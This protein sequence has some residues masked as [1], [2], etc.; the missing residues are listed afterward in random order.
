LI[1]IVIHEIVLF[2][3]EAF[4]H[5]SHQYEH[6][7]STRNDSRNS[8]HLAAQVQNVPSKLVVK[9]LYCLFL[10]GYHRSTEGSICFYFEYLTAAPVD[11]AA[12]HFSDRRI[13]RNDDRCR[14][15]FLL[16]I[17]HLLLLTLRL[18]VLCS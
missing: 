14:A 1:L 18:A 4:E 17:H 16:A 8:H 11:H 7:N 2:I 15:K 13:V 6:R 12:G 9:R 3:F 5:A 10:H